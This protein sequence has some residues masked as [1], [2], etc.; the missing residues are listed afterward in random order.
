MDTPQGNLIQPPKSLPQHQLTR[1]IYLA[2]TSQWVLVLIIVYWTQSS[3]GQQ[4]WL[5]NNWGVPVSLLAG[6]VMIQLSV[7]CGPAIL[8]YTPIQTIVYILFSAVNAFLL[9]V[10]V[11]YFDGQRVLYCAAV[12]FASLVGGSI[13]TSTSR[14]AFHPRDIL[15]Y[16]FAGVAI[17]YQGY[18]M[19]SD[20]PLLFLAVAG[21]IPVFGGAF[22]LYDISEKIAGPVYGLA[23]GQFWVGAVLVWVEY[24]LLPARVLQAVTAQFANPV[25]I[26][27]PRQWWP[28]GQ[29]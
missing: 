8:R 23:P 25:N 9:S 3:A 26:R 13:Y 21:V 2:H 19:F 29:Q 15:I 20:Q 4:S 7:L 1:F 18:V 14:E 24:L 22:L 28:F 10:A 11:I 17:V 16:C 6:W 5:A 12:I 27:I